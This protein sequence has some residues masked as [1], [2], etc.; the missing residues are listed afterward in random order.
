MDK[1]QR[2]RV[3]QM[4]QIRSYRRGNVIALRGESWPFLFVVTDGAIDVVKESAEGRRLILV[5]LE[6]GDIFWGVSFF[7]GDYGQPATFEAREDCRLAMW[8]SDDLVPELM[9][10]S[11]AMWELCQLMM[12]RMQE[13]SKILEGLAFQQVATRLAR[14]ILDQAAGSAQSH[15]SRDATLDEIAAS[16]GSTREVVCRLLYRFSNDNLIEITRT[17]FVLS[18]SQGLNAIANMT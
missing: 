5:T 9:R 8:R 10:N 13:A 18:D 1:E 4:G 17:E 14:Y 12:M 3:A 7:E 2:D 16:I 11:Q 15:L 6:P